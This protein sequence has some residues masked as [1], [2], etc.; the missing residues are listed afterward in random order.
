MKLGLAVFVVAVGLYL[1][2]ARYG[3]VQDDRAVIAANPAAH[4]P[5]AAVRAF[6][7]PYWPPPAEGGLWRPA[8][9]FSFSVDWVVSGGRAGWLHL[10]NALWHGLASVLVLVVLGAWLSPL[11]AAAAALVFAAHPLHVEAVAGLVGRAELLSA[12]ALLGAVLAAR[13]HKWQLTLIAA[14]LA[15][16]AKEHGVVVGVV[17]LLDDWLQGNGRPRYPVWFYA[18]LGAITVGYLAAWSAVGRDATADVA[19]PFLGA[20]PGER[21]AV[22]LPAVLRAATLL[23]WPL[24]LS[25]DYGP[26]VIAVRDSVSLAAIAGALVVVALAASVWLCRR[27][28]PVLAF[29]VGVAAVAYLPTSNLLFASG[30]VLAE[31]NLYLPVVLAAAAVGSV[32]HG[33]AA[34]RGIARAAAMGAVVIAAL[35]ARALLRMPA[36]RDNRAHL[37]TLLSDHPESYRAHASAAA[38]LAGIG[39]TVGAR[40][41]YERATEL[42]DRDPHLLAARGLFL[43]DHGDTATARSLAARARELLPRERNALRIQVTFAIMA[44]DSTRAAALADTAVRWFPSERVWYRHWS[45]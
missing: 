17:I 40:R 41:S 9:I 5:A 8:S 22:A 33:V 35:A 15:M 37:V 20:S 6:A 10:S 1:P 28:A 21:L 32:V 43:M 42:F 11:G 29:A 3:F 18:A 36:W 2:T 13:R 7:R 25:A 38:V 34:R 14:A 23:I 45:Q 4:S 44:G 26:Q 39:D 27:R 19:A 30:V 24:S 16:L 31:R 12:C